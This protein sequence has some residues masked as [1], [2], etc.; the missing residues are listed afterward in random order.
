[1]VEKFERLTKGYALYS[2]NPRAETAWLDNLYAACPSNWW[3]LANRR[4][5]IYDIEN[6]TSA[7]LRHRNPE[8]YHDAYLAAEKAAAEA[9]PRYH[10]ADQDAGRWAHH[11]RHLLAVMQ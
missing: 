1:M 4:H 7:A 9:F 3:A 8:K 10:R 5:R 11:I 2:D 6:L